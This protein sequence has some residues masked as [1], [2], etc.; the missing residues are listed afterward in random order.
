MHMASTMQ[1]ERLQH[2][3]DD[4]VEAM[5]EMAVEAFA[6]DPAHRGFVGG[7]HKLSPLFFRAMACATALD[8]E[9]YVV[10]DPTTSHIASFG[11][12]FPPGK[13]LWATDEQKAL[14]Y[15][16]FFSKLS[17]ETQNWWRHTYPETVAKLRER[18]WS[19]EDSER[20]WWCFNICTDRRHENLG[21]ATAIVNFAYDKAK[22]NDQI[23][24]LSTGT[25]LNVRKYLAMGFR[26]RG[27][28]WIDAPTGGWAVHTLS[29]E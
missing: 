10:K 22:R 3:T 20:C 13:R 17:Q 28:T 7:N 23:L 5:V 21:Y 14:G 9:I 12:W 27:Q 25:D 24:G 29:R 15:N 1:V 19:K 16:E 2:P 26:D 18:T 11:L 4:Q 8:G 6:D